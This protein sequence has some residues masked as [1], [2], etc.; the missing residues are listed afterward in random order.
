MAQ[1]LVS[2]IIPAF[3]AEA[4]LGEALQSAAAQ[5]YPRLE[6]IIV[7][8]GSIDR[9][10]GIAGDFCASE[11]RARFLRTPNRGVAAARNAGIEAASGE[12]LAF[13]DADDLWHPRK[14]EMQVETALAAPG[15]GFVYTLYKRIDCSGK[16]VPAPPQMS[17]QG[18]AFW[19]HLY[20]NFVGSGSS[21][22]VRKEALAEI[23]GF[24]ESLHGCEDYLV[25][26]QLAAK[27]PIAC[28]PEVLVYY[29]QRPSS[30]SADSR[31][32]LHYWRKAIEILTK[33]DILPRNRIVHWTY[34]RACW[35][36]AV[37]DLRRGRILRSFRLFAWAVLSDPARSYHN[38]KRAFSK[39]IGKATRAEAEQVTYELDRRRMRAL[40]DRDER[41]GRLASG[42][43]DRRPPAR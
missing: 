19:R 34:S 5:S 7:D 10:G 27:Y 6:I 36:L 15:A 28:V 17:V 2:V 37:S 16:E 3:N 42:Q 30:A 29:R 12:Y 9:T 8:D 22:L 18:H 4:T 13:L 40:A 26:L 1:P 20:W 31:R 14:L 11:P 33:E 38:G 32:M 21:I 23:G 25:Q 43:G 41:E 24:N 35:G 39:L